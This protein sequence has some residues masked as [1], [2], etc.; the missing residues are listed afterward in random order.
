MTQFQT[1]TTYTISCPSCGN[2]RVVKMGVRNGQ[3]R[4]LCRDCR[5]SFRA[6]GKAKG[7][8]MDAEL[9]GSAVRDYYSG[10]SYKQIAEGLHE[11]YDIPEPSKATVYEWVRDYT[12]RAL[13]Q[14][15]GRKAHTSGHWVADEMYVTVGGKTAYNWNVMDSET[16]YIL[17]SHLSPTRDGR[18]ARAV[19]RKAM[20]NADAPPKTIK[21]DKW[22]AYIKPI[23]DL[24]PGATHIQSQGLTAE[25]N[26]NQS[27]RLQGTFRDREKTLRGLESIESGQR[28]LD[29]WTL[30]YNLFKKHHGLDG[31]TPGE[32]AK[33]NAP[34]EEWA[35]VVKGNTMPKVTVVE[36]ASRSVDLNLDMDKAVA[37]KVPR[38]RL[39]LTG[40]EVEEASTPRH[41]ATSKVDLGLQ[42]MVDTRKPKA[43]KKRVRGV[44]NGSHYLVRKKDR[45]T[46]YRG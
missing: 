17:A 32:A 38:P 5:K 41:R 37:P 35:D 25:I 18:A 22:R 31:G 10:K 36:S 6:N 46:R 7:R 11:E 3:Q 43:P 44:A 28:Y 13:D 8:R 45:G 12:A 24:A 26:N 15:E 21:T 30:Q 20:E 16:R 34:F 29:G 14:M 9:M 23:K 42:R 39:D 1:T 2:S 4:Y 33:I 19:I 40:V 27:E